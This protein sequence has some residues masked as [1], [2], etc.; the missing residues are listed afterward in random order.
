MREPAYSFLCLNSTTMLF[1]EKIVEGAAC[2]R[3]ANGGASGIVGFTFDGG[4]GH[5]IRT[6][7]SDIFLGDANRYGLSAFESSASIK[8]PAVLAGAKIR[9]AF[10]TMAPVG[11][12]HGIGNHG[13]AHGTPQYFL[14]SRHLHS[15]WNIAR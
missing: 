6:F 14:E 7:V 4:P 13:S 3:G 8:V 11:D 2:A 5:E 1:L 10:W 15:P 12:L 9:A